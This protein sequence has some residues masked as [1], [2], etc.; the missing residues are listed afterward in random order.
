VDETDLTIIKDEMSTELLDQFIYECLGKNTEFSFIAK[1]E[2][3]KADNLIYDFKHNKDF[4]SVDNEEKINS[5]DEEILETNNI[6]GKII[7]KYSTF[8][9][10]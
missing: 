1:M 9:E 7:S 3:E 6:K 5:N 10:D 4:E 2:E 8:L